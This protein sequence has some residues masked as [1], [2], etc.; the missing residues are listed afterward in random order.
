MLRISPDITY[1]DSC[2]VMMFA[3]R[4]DVL[5]GGCGIGKGRIDSILRRGTFRTPMVALGESFHMIRQ[6]NP[7][8][9]HEPLNELN[10]LLDTGFLDV[11]FIQDPAAT[12]SLAR[13][14]SE[15]GD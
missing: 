4:D 7:G 11:R 6:K 10:R 9:Y 8:S 14:I 5:R 15:S 3:D 13:V 2:G 12:F 1:L